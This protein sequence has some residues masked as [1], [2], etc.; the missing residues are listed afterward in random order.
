MLTLNCDA[1]AQLSGELK[2]QC[3]LKPINRTGWRDIRR[4][5][6]HRPRVW[7]DWLGPSQTALTLDKYLKSLRDETHRPVQVYWS[8]V[9][10]GPCLA[11]SACQTTSTWMRSHW[12]RQNGKFNTGRVTDLGSFMSPTAWNQKVFF[13]P[14]YYSN[15][16]TVTDFNLV[17]YHVLSPLR[18]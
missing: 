17:M 18:G 6:R 7:G 16:Q 14:D 11:Q 12:P 15:S 8:N 5:L 3:L 9:P 10:P 2:K 1:L 4:A 13:P